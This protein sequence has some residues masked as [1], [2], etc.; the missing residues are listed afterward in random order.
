MDTDIVLAADRIVARYGSIEALHGVSLAIRRGQIVALL[1]ANG[2]GKSTTLRTLSGLIAASSGSVRFLGEDITRVPAHRLPQRGLVH[3]PEGR[4]IFGDMT[5]RENLD[6]GSFTLTDDA[7]RRRRLDHVFELFPIL[8]KRHNGDARN[9]SGGEQQMLAIGRALMAAPKVL[10]LDEPSMGL[11]PQ[12]IKEVMN[13]VQRLN[14]E[15]VTILLVEQNS[16]V[17]LKFADYGY[18]LKGGRIVLEGRGTDLANDDA[19]V[20][21]YLGGVAA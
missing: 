13:I 5:I 21:A 6:L 15:G 18:V 16:K 14:R 9:L 20:S 19:V 3:V 1:G 8:A 7:E 4:R 11:A 12:L 2:A 10:L 17:A